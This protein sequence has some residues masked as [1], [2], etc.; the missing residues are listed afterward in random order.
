VEMGFMTK[1]KVQTSDIGIVK[2]KL[3]KFFSASTP[4]EV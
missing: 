2:S 3:Y 4:A 1:K